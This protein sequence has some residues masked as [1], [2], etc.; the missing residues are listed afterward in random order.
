MRRGYEDCQDGQNGDVVR[1]ETG[2]VLTREIEVKMKEK[3]RCKMSRNC[4]VLLTDNM[5]LV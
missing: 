1:G 3:P 4:I 5:Y 2:C